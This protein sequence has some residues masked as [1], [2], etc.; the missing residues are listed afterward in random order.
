[1][2]ATQFSDILTTNKSKEKDST[3]T[4]KPKEF[5]SL[6]DQNKYELFKKSCLNYTL[7]DAIK[8][9]NLDK[10]DSF[11][12]QVEKNYPLSKEKLQF[13]IKSYGFI[14]DKYSGIRTDKASQK[15]QE[16]YKRCA[17]N[18]RKLLPFLNKDLSKAQTREDKKRIYAQIIQTIRTSW[19][20]DEDNMTLAKSLAEIGDFLKENE[21]I[22]LESFEGTPREY[23][24]DEIY[25]LAIKNAAINFKR[26]KNK[27]ENAAIIEFTKETENKIKDKT[28]L[29]ITMK[30]SITSPD[31]WQTLK[32]YF[33]S[34]RR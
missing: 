18:A 8:E 14:A 26:W 4:S 22:R 21:T 10:L 5:L 16:S 24:Q 34:D 32:N 20:K 3:M 2:Q 23:N 29:E 1:M 9:K 17:D 12:L 33:S 6:I 28:K 11:L 13:L 25:I 15:R 19:Q 31:K 7:S 27:E 30:R